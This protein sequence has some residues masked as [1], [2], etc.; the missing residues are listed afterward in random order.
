M[1]MAAMARARSKV[2]QLRLTPTE[3]ES[4]H[5]SA[6]RRRTTLADLIRSAVERELERIPDDELPDPRAGLEAALAK[7]EALV[8]GTAPP[9]SSISVASEWT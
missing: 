5:E 9:P 6:W 8:G 4:W 2:Y 3:F 7:L 1:V